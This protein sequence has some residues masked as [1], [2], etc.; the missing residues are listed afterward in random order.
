MKLKYEKGL[1]FMD[2]IIEYGGKC[3]TLKN[4]VLDSG[5]SHTI[6]NPDSINNLDIKAEA[7]DKFITMYGI[8]GEHYAYRKKIDSIIIADKK[9]DSVEVDFGT[10]D[11]EG[12]ISG[13]LGLDMLLKVGAIIDFNNL[14]LSVK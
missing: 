5:A 14:M 4:I 13:L 6:I 9:V 7:D 11:E 1:I 3:E 2:L 12:K 8:G 10:I